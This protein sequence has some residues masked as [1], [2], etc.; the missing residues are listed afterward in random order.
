MSWRRGCGFLCARGFTFACV[1]IFD[2]IEEVDGKNVQLFQKYFFALSFELR[3]RGNFLSTL[4][5]TLVLFLR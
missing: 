1:C 2:F 5:S 4:F 3:T